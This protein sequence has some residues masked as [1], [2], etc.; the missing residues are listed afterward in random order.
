[1]LSTMFSKGKVLGILLGALIMLGGAAGAQ[2]DG[3]SRRCED[4]IAYD[5][6]VARHGYYSRQADHERRELDRL[7]AQCGNRDHY[8]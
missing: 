5:R 6:A 1:M 8:R 4:R 2:A 3:W 7:Y